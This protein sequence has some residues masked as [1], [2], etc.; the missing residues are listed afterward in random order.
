MN[1]LMYFIIGFV[2][3]ALNTAYEKVFKAEEYDKFLRDNKGEEVVISV[4]YCAMI[5]LWP[6]I[7][8]YELFKLLTKIFEWIMRSFK[9]E[10]ENEE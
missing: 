9:D 3:V 5:T 6:I 1:V 7:I 10:D 4:I 8:L 2:V